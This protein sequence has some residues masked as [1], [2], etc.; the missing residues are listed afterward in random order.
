MPCS[1][2]PPPTSFCTLPGTRVGVWL[3][4]TREARPRWEGTVHAAQ[5]A[6]GQPVQG[7]AAGTRAAARL[8]PRA[9][10]AAPHLAQVLLLGG[11]SPLRPFRRDGHFGLSFVSTF[12]RGLQGLISWAIRDLQGG[13]GGQFSSRRE[14]QGRPAR[15]G[16]HAHTGRRLPAHALAA[17]FLTGVWT[18]WAEIRKERLS[19]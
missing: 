6:Q 4:V 18:S 13:G 17:G 5:A 3:S 19:T 10:Q 1:P 8:A 9:R 14:L 7:W 15:R 2:S 12:V 16:P 11:C